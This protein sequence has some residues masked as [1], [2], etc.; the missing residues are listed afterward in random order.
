MDTPSSVHTRVEDASHEPPVKVKRTY[1]RKRETANVEAL[2]TASDAV[3]RMLPDLAKETGLL[4]ES[5]FMSPTMPRRDVSDLFGWKKKLAEIDEQFDDKHFQ[6]PRKYD[7]T[8]THGNDL[9]GSGSVQSISTDGDSFETHGNSPLS[10]SMLPFTSSQSDPPSPA[11]ARSAHSGK[12]TV[13]VETDSSDS[14]VPSKAQNSGA[15]SPQVHHLNGIPQVRHSA[16]PP[17]PGAEPMT[18]GETTKHGDS[19]RKYRI[20]HTEGRVFPRKTGSSKPKEKTN[21]IK[22]LSRKEEKESRKAHARIMA[23]QKISVTKRA[24]QFT[25]NDLLGKLQHTQ[26]PATGSK[27]DVASS[28]PIQDF[29]SSPMLN[30][31]DTLTILQSL[32]GPSGLKGSSDEEHN[33]REKQLGSGQDEDTSARRKKSLALIKRRALEAKVE[34][35]LTDTDDDDL[36]VVEGSIHVETL[37]RRSKIATDYEKR[38]ANVAGYRMGGTNRHSLSESLEGSQGEKVLKLAAKSAFGDR[39]TRRSSTAVGHRSLQ[40]AMLKRASKQSVALTREKEEEWQRRGGKLPSKQRIVSSD[41]PFSIQRLAEELALRKVQTERDDMP[42]EVTGNRL[43]SDDS[44][45]E[46]WNPESHGPASPTVD[47]SLGG[48]NK[49]VLGGNVANVGDIDFHNQDKRA[50]QQASNTEGEHKSERRLRKPWRTASRMVMSDSE[51]EE[52]GELHC[53]DRVLVPDTSV[54]ISDLVHGGSISPLNESVLDEENKENDTPLLFEIGEDKENLVMPLYP[55]IEMGSHQPRGVLLV[56]GT[57]RTS[58]SPNAGTHRERKPLQVRKRDDVDDSLAS[59]SSIISNSPKASRMESASSSTRGHLP[60]DFGWETRGFSQLF[61]DDDNTTHYDKNTSSSGPLKPGFQFQISHGVLDFP[62]QPSFE[63]K[64]VKSVSLSD[65]FS[66]ESQPRFTNRMQRPG[67]DE[68]F[69]LTLDTKLQPALEVTTQ[70]RRKADAIFEKEQD[71]LLEDANDIRPNNEQELYVT[72]NGLLTQT[73]PEGSTPVVYRSWTPSQKPTTIASQATAPPTTQRIPLSTLSFTSETSSPSQHRLSRL[74]KGKGRAQSPADGSEL[75]ESR[76]NPIHISNAFTELLKA[77]KKQKSSEKRKL[78]KSEYIEGEALE[79]DEDELFGF[80]GAKKDDDGES[81]DEDPDAVVEDLV[82]DTIMDPE[83]LAEER[84]LEKVKEQTEQD[85]AA[86]QKYHQA[87]IEGKYRSKRRTGGVAMDDSDS[88]D[89]EDDEA[90]RLRQRMHKKRRIEGDSLEALSK[91]ER[92]HAFYEAYQ[93]D[94]QDDDNED[95]AHLAKDDMDI[96]DDGGESEQ[97]EVV[98]TSEIQTR[99]REVARQQKGR[100]KEF[101]FDPEDADWAQP[102]AL[103]DDE[104]NVKEVDDRPKKSA[105]RRPVFGRLDIVD[106]DESLPRRSNAWSDVQ[107]AAW[108]KE[109]GGRNLGTGGTRGAVTV[110]GHGCSS[111]ASRKGL[112]MPRTSLPAAGEAQ[113]ERRKVV[114]TTSMLAKISDKHSRFGL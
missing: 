87:A 42:D 78:G 64:P 80:G 106:L 60:P 82:D 66:S 32:A 79:S 33:E 45:D 113:S 46:D 94:V 114:K 13:V 11:L 10:L 23:D 95:F 86:L 38:L 54:V 44:D 76:P 88:D 102:L 97:P 58:V 50:L 35:G 65:V 53:K 20:K 89:D 96:T 108:R 77:S 71:F 62:L 70:V 107:L 31:T 18:E 2:D 24:E 34:G 25:I 29:T 9:K 105:P 81:D 43:D 27:V 73:K 8:H 17:S 98:S 26:R 6:V 57:S 112:S 67:D 15:M 14:D 93:R 12:K 101:S 22:K 111:S 28:D 83:Q 59:R 47:K 30:P 55:S 85:D 91:D 103:S 1:G 41:E 110:T 5:P 92:S 52:T 109:Q 37:P 4:D 75:P 19:G 84:V 40:S 74:V 63:P 48:S 39:Y 69:S 51:E 104:F 36:E 68:G 16:A 49:E 99:L 100:E 56:E 21:A 7:A 72:E 90:R 3:A 61:D